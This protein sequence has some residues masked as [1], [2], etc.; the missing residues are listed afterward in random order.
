MKMT[1]TDKEKTFIIGATD[2]YD[3][4]LLEN[5][6][7]IEGNT[8]AI[9]LNDLT[10][11]DDCSFTSKDFITR[12]GLFLFTLGK[13]MR[14]AGYNLLDEVSV[15]T[16]CTEEVKN[17]LNTIGGYKAIEHLMSVVNPKNTEA[18]FDDF[19]KSNTLLKLYAN[20]FNLFKEVQLDN[21]KI[22]TPFNLFK[23]FTASEVIDWYD[24]KINTF[25]TV[26]NNKITGEE[27]ID[28]D[29]NFLEELKEGKLLGTS[30]ADCGLDINGNKISCFPFLS[31]A[32]LG[33]GTG[34]HAI[35]GHVGTGK[36][37]IAMQIVLSL[38]ANGRKFIIVE[39]EVD[40]KNLKLI[41]LTFILNRYFNYFGVTRKKLKSGALNQE[42]TIMV[43]KAFQYWKDV[44]K[45]RL[46][47][48]SMSDSDTDLTCSIIKKNILREG[49]DGFFVDTFKLNDSDG[50]SDQ[51][52]LSMIK[53]S[54][55]LH[56][57]ALKYDVCGVISIQLA[58]ATNNRLWLDKSCLSTAK[59]V[60]E[61]LDTCIGIR[62]VLQD[63]LVEG[64]SIYCNPF[65]S[66]QNENG[67][68]V[69]VPYTN[70][71]PT[72]T[73]RMLFI[74]KNRN[75][76][77]SDDNGV[78]YLLR[79]SGDYCSMYETTKARSSMKLKPS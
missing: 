27:V 29:D 16:Q 46:K 78:T 67:E 58:P 60:C 51:F 64:S 10:M 76:P 54:K 19:F 9:L 71:D 52:W 1:A 2:K 4:R 45:K 3:D 50:I 59:G 41:I 61:V 33:F 35:V 42:E 15:M 62:P 70:A 63:E 20:G 55:R 72:K 25:G 13:T 26:S 66:Q 36:T 38:I 40:I 8:V 57:I 28:F 53:D 23:N 24:A 18:I 30:Y 6:V 48:V 17:R 37:T 74:I 75:G 5:R 32:T 77:G 73:W 14:D 79:F 69:E 47:I 34:L 7:I 39:N 12:D 43:K 31:S 44:F 65:R 56:S 22:A 68:W 11:Y 21:G 49:Y